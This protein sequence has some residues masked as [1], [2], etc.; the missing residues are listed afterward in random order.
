MLATGQRHPQAV[1][2]WGVIHDVAVDGDAIGE[3][4]VERDAQAQHLEG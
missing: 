4:G 3:A 1:V 2:A